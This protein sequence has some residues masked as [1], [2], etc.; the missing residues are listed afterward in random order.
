MSAMVDSG[1]ERV[2]VMFDG[3]KL[4]NLFLNFNIYLS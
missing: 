4:K 1:R 3:G 2:C